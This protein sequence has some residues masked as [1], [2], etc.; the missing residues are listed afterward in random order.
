MDR[1]I[2]QEVQILTDDV[3]SKVLEI[4]QKEKV[5][6]SWEFQTDVPED[7]MQV[8]ELKAKQQLE[9]FLSFNPDY[10]K[11][12]KNNGRAIKLV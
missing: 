12:V 7:N 2:R 5:Q 8:L 3:K 6:K 4:L 10:R 11:V 1:W 9:S